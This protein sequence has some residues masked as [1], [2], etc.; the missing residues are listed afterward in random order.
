MECFGKANGGGRRLTPREPAPVTAVIFTLTRTVSAV[1][2]DVSATGARLRG[3]RLPEA[4]EELILSIHGTRTYGTVA[5]VVGD[6]CGV[7]FGEP[8][9]L[10]SFQALRDAAGIAPGFT[11]ELKAAYEDWM[12]GV[13]R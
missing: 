9:A 13:A 11:P 7:E 10:D 4:G 3:E 1:V 2:V 5:W 8:L 6:E 12:I